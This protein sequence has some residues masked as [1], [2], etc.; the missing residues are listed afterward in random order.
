MQSPWATVTG[1]HP[2]YHYHHYGLWHAWVKCVHGDDEIDFWNLKHGKGRVTYKD[3]REFIVG[4]D[5]AG[6]TVIQEQIGYKGE[7]KKPV[8]ILEEAFTII[9]RVV[10]GAYEIDYQVEQKNVTGESLKLLAW[11]LGGPI[12][13]HAPHHWRNGNSDYL[14]SE[15]KTRVDGHATRSRWISMWGPANDKKGSAPVSFAILG[16]PNNHDAPQ[17][18]RIWPPR[19]KDGAIFFNYVPIQ[20]QAWEIMPGE[21]ITMRYRLVL[22]DEK[23]D[24]DQLNARWEQWSRERH[25]EVL[26]NLPSAWRRRAAGAKGVA[27]R[28]IM[29]DRGGAGAG[30]DRHARLFLD[31]SGTGQ[32]S[33]V[34]PALRRAAVGRPLSGRDFRC[35][36]PCLHRVETVLP[37]GEAGSPIPRLDRVGGCRLP[38]RVPQGRRY[39]IE[40]NC[41]KGEARARVVET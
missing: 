11:R 26:A 2:S 39:A 36:A 9:A 25:P 18:M 14:S 31:A 5:L 35:G 15:G 10:D 19:A 28:K 37:G 32:P 33:S 38:G 29:V 16:H 6:F 20:E 13:Y 21:S 12:A 40:G 27:A 41:E 8:T 3:T 30:R 34:A 1:I 24:V 22:T 7:K 4:N 23:A 17:R